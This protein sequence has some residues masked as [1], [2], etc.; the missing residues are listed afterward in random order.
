MNETFFVVLKGEINTSL[1]A[2]IPAIGG[3][4]AAL[5]AA[6]ISTRVGSGDG[7][8]VSDGASVGVGGVEGDILS[9]REAPAPGVRFHTPVGG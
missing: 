5:I 9:Q 7:V 1:S 6:A 2:T 3:G 8:G 4:A